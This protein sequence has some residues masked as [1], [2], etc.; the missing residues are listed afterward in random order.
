[1]LPYWRLS[2][3]YFFYFAFIGAF[4]P[5]FGLYLESIEFSAWDIGL[6]MSLMQ[7]M[8]IVAP[9]LWG[10][11]ADR[12]G[13][14]MPIVRLAALFSTLGFCLFFASREFAA[15]FAAMA[16]MSFFWSAALPLI[17]SLTLR[18]L[19]AR[20]AR[21]GAIR[22][23]GSIGFIVAVTATGWLLDALPI[24]SLLVVCLS[25]LAGILVCAMFVPE[26]PAGALAHSADSLRSLLERAEVRA[27]L[28]ACFLMSAAHGAL[29]VFYSIYLVDNGYAKSVVGGMWTVGVL[30]EIVVFIYMPALM[31]RYSLRAILMA[32]FACAVVR[33]LM[34]G[35]GVESTL[36]LFLAQ[37]LHGATFG[38]YHAAALSAINRLFV[39]RHQTRGQALYSSVSFGAGGMV[40]GLI[41]GWAWESI[42][43]ALTYSLSAAIAALGLGLV[44]FAGHGQA[45]AEAR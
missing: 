25:I 36:I 42:G 26:A 20:I 9:N 45:A 27:L 12:F 6:V 17:E 7:L 21:Y 11:M 3:Y 19:G 39:G 22:L 31:A 1:M 35:W 38:A 37:L 30:A 44:A 24:S 8:R 29:Y 10:W 14:R 4:A 34:I 15:V 16:L 23:W 40:G 32:S 5:Y 28:G 41:S 18:H 13:M 33:F 43:A 2:A